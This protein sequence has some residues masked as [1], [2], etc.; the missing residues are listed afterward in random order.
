MFTHPA[1]V[2]YVLSEFGCRLGDYRVAAADV[3]FVGRHRLPTCRD[4][5]CQGA[6]DLVVEVVS[7]RD[8]WSA[9]EAKTQEWL[10]AGAQQVRVVD[11]AKELV[12]VRCEGHATINVLKPGGTLL[13]PPL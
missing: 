5:Y 3:A 4:G 2:G 11:Q 1:S 7:P 13:S 8:T 12:H 9:L 6:P 10:A